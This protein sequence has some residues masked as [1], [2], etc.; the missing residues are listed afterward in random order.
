M[1]IIRET[2][3][4]K[5]ALAELRADGGRI[6]LVP[7][8]GALH[9]GHMALVA[10]ARR[11]ADHVVASIFVNPTQ[12]GPNE[13]FT[14]YPRTPEDDRALL[15]IGRAARVLCLQLQT[16]DYEPRSGASWAE[17]AGQIRDALERIIP[18]E[19]IAEVARS[20]SEWGSPSRASRS[21]PPTHHASW[22]APSSTR[23]ISMT[24]AEPLALSSAPGAAAREM[25]G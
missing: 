19:T 11:R 3:A 2:G 9:A 18:A 16:Q 25:I 6:A 15:E 12:F 13:D 22:P 7:T 24:P 20:K 10:E 17:H 8:M 4:L 14:A 1:Q 5:A 21:A 23:A